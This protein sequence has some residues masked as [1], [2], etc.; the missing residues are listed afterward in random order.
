MQLSHIQ[1]TDDSFYYELVPLPDS[2][3][4]IAALK[5]I[6]T[7]YS[8]FV[9]KIPL[10]PEGRPLIKKFIEKNILIDIIEKSLYQ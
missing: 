4:F 2:S 3:F 9:N 7:E 5:T 8:V 10:C 1:I 6:G